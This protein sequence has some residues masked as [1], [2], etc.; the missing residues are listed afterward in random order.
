[1][2]IIS[3]LQEWVDGAVAYHAAVH[4]DLRSLEAIAAACDSMGTL[5]LIQAVCTRNTYES[6]SSIY[7]TIVAFQDETRVKA[8]QAGAAESLVIIMQ[9]CQEAIF[10]VH[11]LFLLPV[12]K[13]NTTGDAA[14]RAVSALEGPPVFHHVALLQGAEDCTIAVLFNR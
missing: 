3:L 10:Q 12:F 13:N 14:M 8:I 7:L 9:S 2:A 1:M 4:S 6:V 11:L 5:L